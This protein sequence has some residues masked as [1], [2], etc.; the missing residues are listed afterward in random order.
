MEEQFFNSTCQL[1]FQLLS[2]YIK[3]VITNAS[4][5]TYRREKEITVSFDLKSLV[6]VNLT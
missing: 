6:T 1:T 4:K 2:L 5:V 3:I